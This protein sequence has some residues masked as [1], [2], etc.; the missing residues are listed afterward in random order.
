MKIR[1]AIEHIESDH[2]ELAG[3]ARIEAIKDLREHPERHKACRTA[4]RETPGAAKLQ[5]DESG[6][7]LGVTFGDL[8]DLV[9]QGRELGIG[10]TTVVTGDTYIAGSPV[11]R[12]GYTVKYLEV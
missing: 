11:E 4:V 12:K 8:C 10:R 1:E 6:R 5:V 3:S 9:D 7:R 2:P